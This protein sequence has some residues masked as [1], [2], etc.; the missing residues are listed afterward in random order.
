MKCEFPPLSSTVGG[1]ASLFFCRQHYQA[2][3]G[4]PLRSNSKARKMSDI[5]FDFLDPA[6]Q[7]H[8]LNSPAMEPPDGV[9]SDFDH[10]PNKNGLVT[11]I[12]AF[13]VALTSVVLVA[14]IYIRFISIKRPFIGDC[15]CPTLSSSARCSRLITFPRYV[16]AWICMPPYRGPH[17]FRLV[18]N[19]YRHYS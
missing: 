7:A 6:Q 16:D 1:P 2:T 10:P 19:K 8:V 3:R 18:T 11:F 15:E 4:S 17:R 13:C 5:N 12:L 14:R 9:V